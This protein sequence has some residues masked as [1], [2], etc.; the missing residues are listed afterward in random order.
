MKITIISALICAALISVG[1]INAKNEKGHAEITSIHRAKQA[2]HVFLGSTKLIAAGLLSL[3]L[4]DF[5]KAFIDGNVKYKDKNEM[6]ICTLTDV[7]CIPFF[8]LAMYKL[9]KSGL[10]SLKRAL[11]K[12]SQMENSE[13]PAQLDQSEPLEA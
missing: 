1:S 11:K 13:A 9:G 12:P 8:C 6:L 3:P 2:K 10:R 4:I 5:A 7:V